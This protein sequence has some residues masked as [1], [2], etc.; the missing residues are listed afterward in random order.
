MN[1]KLFHGLILV[2]AL[3]AIAVDFF[4]YKTLF[5]FF[6]PL[7]TALIILLVFCFR[8]GGGNSYSNSILMGL[9]FCLAGDVFLLSSDFFVYGLGSFLIGHLLF[10]KA[11]VKERG[12]YFP[13]EVGI[14]L[15]LFGGV[16]LWLSYPNLEQLFIP[17]VL[18]MS[19]IILMSWQGIALNRHSSQK[20]FQSI[21]LAVTLFLLSDALIALDKFYFSFS[22]SGLLVLSTYWT[23]IFLLAESTT[24]KG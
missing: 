18:Y 12:W 15:I 24:L 4:E 23:A 22:F 10:L 20:A 21:G 13:L 11:F 8:Y 6:K 19:V 17:V 7:T 1:K 3:L 9:F 16:L 2:S 5:F 14:P